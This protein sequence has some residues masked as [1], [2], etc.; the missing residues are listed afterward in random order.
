[1]KKKLILSLILIL[2]SLPIISAEINNTI[3]LEIEQTT[4]NNIIVSELNN[5]A[6]FNLKIKNLGP[7]DNFQIYSL[8]GVDMT[9][10]GTFLL[11]SG[12]TKNI[13][14]KVYALER[15]RNKPGTL[16]FVYKIHGQDTGIQSELLTIKIM[17]LQEALELGS[18][19]INPNSTQATIF[20]RNNVNA[21]FD[22]KADFSSAFF[23]SSK[24]FHIKELETKFFNITLN[25]DK[26][27]TL[28]AGKYIITAKLLLQGESQKITGTL[29]FEEQESIS[30]TD[31]TSGFFFRKQIIK[32]TNEGNIPIVANVNIRKNIISRLFTT[33]NIEPNQVTRQGIYVYYN[34]QK[35][36]NPSETLTIK[37]TTSWLYPI[38]LILLILIIAYLVYIYNITDLI[39]KKRVAFVKTKGGEFALKVFLRVK[40][41]RYVERIEINDKLPGLVKIHEK[42]PG[43]PP[44]KIDVKKR[45]IIWNIESLDQGEERI[46][47]YIVYS[48]VGIIGK[49]ELPPAI[50]SYEREGEIKQAVSN[51]TYFMNEPIKKTDEE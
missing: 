22:I 23:D 43:H 25:K 37:I 42:F 45:R 6:T 39:L 4:I 48:K 11:K 29:K 35:E 14:V 27:K 17:P 9:P 16:T 30:T 19:P 28:L 40:A 38:S 31:S 36:I 32:K 8:I 34:I 18:F 46:F 33:F 47:S 12:E 49:F 20:I 13:E 24:N 50:A 51:K 10:K 44:D 3:N 21:P 2:M 15:L 26:M 41:R 1:M 7:A 5:P